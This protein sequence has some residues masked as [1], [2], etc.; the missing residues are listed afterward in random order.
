M[1]LPDITRISPNKTP[2]WNTGEPHVI[3]V[4]GT[5]GG[6]AY[7][8][9]FQATLNWFDDP[10]SQASAHWVIARDGRTA[11]IVPD[12]HRAWHAEEHNGVAVGVE[13]EQPKA[14]DQITTP[15]YEKL[16]L[17]G[18]TCYP[19]IPM[20]HLTTINRE[21][22]WIE[23]MET[24]QGI[25][26]GKSDVGTFDWQAFLEEDEMLSNEDKVWLGSYGRQ[27][28][29]A[30]TEGGAFLSALRGDPGYSEPVHD[31]KDVLD[32]LAALEAKVNAIQSGAV[33]KKVLFPGATIKV[34]P[35]DMP[36]E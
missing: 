19:S 10:R 22:G 2:G 6:A 14:S 24:P 28:V 5:R 4:H 30:I 32:R 17:I 3:I 27:L 11:R 18:R 26:V 31:L 29:K 34:P 35:V 20:V 33:P 7:G 23:H 13:L 36:V 1:A 12:S 9:E 16:A 8:V 25:R 21:V 15:Q